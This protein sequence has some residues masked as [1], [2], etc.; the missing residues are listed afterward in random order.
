VLAG[1]PTMTLAAITHD[2]V[3]S[4]LKKLKP[5]RSVCPDGLPPYVIKACAELFVSPLCFI[6]NL[7]IRHSHF[8]DFLKKIQSCSGF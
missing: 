4:A 5:K 6:F 3:L 7:S 2:E 8:P 1:L